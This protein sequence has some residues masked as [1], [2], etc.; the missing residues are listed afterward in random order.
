MCY[1]N[2]KLIVF[3][4]RKVQPK[5]LLK[6]AVSFIYNID[7]YYYYYYYYLT[8]AKLII[9]NQT[10]FNTKRIRIE[11]T[12]TSP[13]TSHPSLLGYEQPCLFIF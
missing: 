2:L 10:L 5:S 1:L 3:L 9:I 8:K 4:E 6:G 11:N 13:R 12:M 7:Y